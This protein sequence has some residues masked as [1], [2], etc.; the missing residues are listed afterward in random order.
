[1]EQHRKRTSGR[2][3]QIYERRIKEQLSERVR[4][5]SEETLIS[6]WKPRQLSRVTLNLTN[7]ARSA[8]TI[9]PATMP[10]A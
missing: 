9:G 7:S 10:G 4:G 5:T 6:C 2:V 3:V 1:M 8:L